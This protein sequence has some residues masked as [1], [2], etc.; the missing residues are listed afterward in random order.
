MALV[1]GS[2]TFCSHSLLTRYTEGCLQSRWQVHPLLSGSIVTANFQP[3]H[4]LR[5]GTRF[6]HYAI[7]SQA[8]PDENSTTEA[9]TN[10][11]SETNTTSAKKAKER[12]D[13]RKGQATAIITGAIAVLLGVGYLILVQ[14]LD[15]R[16]VV[17]QPPPPEAFEP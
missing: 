14:I 13:V 2:P 17:L 10:S 6:G 7:R 4:F 15:T 5:C 8:S 1:L 11:E 12:A 16:G 9:P 3:Y